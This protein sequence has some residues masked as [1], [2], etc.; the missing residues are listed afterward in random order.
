MKA[1]GLLNQA[2]APQAPPMPGGGAQVPG[3]PTSAQIMFP[4]TA[5]GSGMTPDELRRRQML[6][7]GFG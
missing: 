5:Q 1:M 3:M 7:Q 6:M 4:Q 2:P